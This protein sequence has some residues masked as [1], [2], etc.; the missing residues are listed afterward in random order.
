[1]YSSLIKSKKILAASTDPDKPAHSHPANDLLPAEA[2]TL[3]LQQSIAWLDEMNDRMQ[4]LK[5]RGHAKS[6]IFIS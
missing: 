5:G 4:A 6:Y 2:Y 1:M 3:L